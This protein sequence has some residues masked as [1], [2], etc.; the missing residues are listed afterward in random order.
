MGQLPLFT[1]TDSNSHQLERRN[2][3]LFFSSLQPRSAIS[4]KAYGI[5]WSP[6][7]LW[8]ETVCVLLSWSLL[9]FVNLP[10]PVPG[11]L[12][13]KAW[14]AVSD[15]D[16]LCPRGQT[17]GLGSAIP[18]H[19]VQQAPKQETNAAMAF[20]N[21]YL[22]CWHISGVSNSARGIFFFFCSHESLQFKSTWGMCDGTNIWVSECRD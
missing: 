17:T 8:R 5:C 7:P 4:L 9:Q 19:L 3:F 14:C 18:R 11:T 10:L 12:G 22:I 2:I 16:S 20:H 1:L 21:G 13:G 6:F 15:L